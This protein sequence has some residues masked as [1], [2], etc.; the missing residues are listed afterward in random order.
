MTA[1]TKLFCVVCQRASHSTEECTILKQA[2]PVAK[3]VGYG[4]RGLGCLLVQHTKDIVAA[5]HTNPMALV[6]VHFGHLNETTV[7]FGFSKMFEWGWTWRAKFQSHATFLMRFPNK[8]K[9]VELAKFN[10][11]NL[12][13]TGVII[14]VQP[15]SLDH[16]TIGKMHTAWVKFE[17]VPN[18][19]RH[20]FG[21]CEVAAAV[22]PR[23]SFVGVGW[24]TFFWV[25]VMF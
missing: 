12:L 6:I 23:F 15:W 9:L 14:K 19:F 13:G 3:Y 1:K 5:E 8:A 20:L 21:M 22:G 10:D 25:M 4:A 18:C 16:L 17:K 11:F 2:K 24:E 7:A